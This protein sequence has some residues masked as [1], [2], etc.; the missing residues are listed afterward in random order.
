MCGYCFEAGPLLELVERQRVNEKP[1]WHRGCTWLYI[2]ELRALTD[3]LHVVKRFDDFG[4]WRFLLV[5]RCWELLLWR[6]GESCQEL[7]AE[8]GAPVLEQFSRCGPLTDL[9]IQGVADDGRRLR[10][11]R[12]ASH[13]RFRDLAVEKLGEYVQGVHGQESMAGERASAFPEYLAAFLLV[14]AFAPAHEL[15]RRLAIEETRA[16]PPDDIGLDL[17]LQ[18]KAARHY[19]RLFGPDFLLEHYAVMR[20]ELVLYLLMQDVLAPCQLEELHRR[21]RRHPCKGQVVSPATLDRYLEYRSLAEG[22]PDSPE[23]GV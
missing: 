9:L 13:D 17:W 11:L 21:H 8:L 18:R 14:K 4:E 22:Q 10:S 5:Y 7:K 23:Q 12:G 6:Q 16:N 2:Q 20:M 3:H 19:A 1:A 15:L